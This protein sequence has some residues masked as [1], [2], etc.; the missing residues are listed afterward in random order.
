M[1]WYRSFYENKD[2]NM[3]DITI[4]QI[5]EFIYEAKKNKILWSVE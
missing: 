3:K 1:E 4:K 2:A 5:D